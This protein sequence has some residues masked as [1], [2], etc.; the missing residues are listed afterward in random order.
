MH[1]RHSRLP[2]LRWFTL[3]VLCAMTLTAI[4][5]ATAQ[6]GNLL[7]NPGFEGEY[8]AFSGDVR[9]LVAPGWSAWN[10]PRR[11]GEPSW[12][13]ITP[14]Y[15]PADTT[16]AAGRVRSGQRAQEFYELYATFT[17]GVYQQV[18]V[19]PGAPVSFSAHINVWSTEL[20][21]P[22]ESEQA[23]EVVVQVGIDPTGGV[24]GESP[25]I[26]WG[27]SATFYDEYRK[28]EAQAVASGSTVTVFVRAIMNDPVRHNHVYVDD[29]ELT[30]SG[31]GVT[32]VPSSATP[33]PTPITPAPTTAVPPTVVGQPSNTPN[34]FEP[35]R[36]GTVQP[37]TPGGPTLIP[38]TVEIR[39][40]GATTPNFPDLPGRITHVVTRGDTVGELAVRYNSRVDAI[41]ALNNLR[42]DGLIV[43]GQTLTIPVPQGVPTPTNTLTIGT[44]VIP[45]LPPT[46]PPQTGGS[47][48]DTA[49][50][51]GPTLNGIGTYI[52][53]PGDTFVAVARR[54]NVSVEQL[55]RQNGIVN[56]ALVVIGQVLAVPGPG[57][58]P[59]GGTVAPT[60]VPTQ[61]GVPTA[62]PGAGG[63]THTVQPGENLFRISLRYNVSLAALMQANGIVNPN[64]IYAGQVLRIP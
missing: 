27:S 61:P 24:N 43:L 52:M 56:P 41:I 50:L 59:P 42:A 34:P 57:N 10:I 44:P 13:N 22:A 15:L 12:S 21:D 23:G 9:R 40:P 47:P 38:P 28:L 11:A 60:I 30:S 54:Y 49:V 33:S 2:G 3:I 31:G 62:A 64:L 17:G 5:P 55:A 63:G 29:A 32:S 8:A 53:Q 35:T 18:N 45:T 6:S 48:V 46:Q 1:N 14:Q 58:N 37:V 25:S 26:V 20:D 7:T 39:T 19:A 51:N 4:G 36:E 16:A